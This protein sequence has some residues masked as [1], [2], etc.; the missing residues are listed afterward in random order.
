MRNNTT[1]KCHKIESG[2]RPNPN[3]YRFVGFIPTVKKLYKKQSYKEIW[4]CWSDDCDK[5]VEFVSDEKIEA[6]N[7]NI[8]YQYRL[9]NLDK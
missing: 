5:K 6:D 7:V 2:K 9:T 1:H 4:A 8:C 3:H